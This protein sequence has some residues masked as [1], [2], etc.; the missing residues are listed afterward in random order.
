[1]TT[2]PRKKSTFD[3]WAKAMVA[4][5]TVDKPDYGKKTRWSPTT[6]KQSTRNARRRRMKKKRKSRNGSKD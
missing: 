1:M 3:L 2:Y 4:G 5:A 6:N